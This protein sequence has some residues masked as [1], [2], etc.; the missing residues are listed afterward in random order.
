LG[1]AHLVRRRNLF[2]KGVRALDAAAWGSAEPRR[3]QGRVAGRGVLR[4]ALHGGQT[5]DLDNVDLD[6]LGHLVLPHLG[7]D[8]E[9]RRNTARRHTRR[10][11]LSRF[12]SGR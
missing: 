3:V 2:P 7:D 12:F 4:T 5:D 11:Q 9:E 6:E 10:G 8:S 1:V